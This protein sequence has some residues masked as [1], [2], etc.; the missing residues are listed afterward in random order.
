LGIRGRGSAADIGLGRYTTLRPIVT[1]AAEKKDT[2]KIPKTR[3]IRISEPLYQ[4]FV[5]FSKRYYDVEPYDLILDN[6]L[7]CYEEHYQD[8]SWRDM[9]VN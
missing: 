1:T 4:K 3:V 7:K 9:K 8:K 5:N 2:N 6:L